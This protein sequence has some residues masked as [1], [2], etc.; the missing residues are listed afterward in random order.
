[1]LVRILISCW[2]CK[3]S[4]LPWASLCASALLYAESAPSVGTCRSLMCVLLVSRS[5][6]SED[7]KHLLASL[8]PAAATVDMSQRQALPR[9]D[10][11]SA[12]LAED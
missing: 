9:D 5:D 6:V 8:D 11:K 10:Q 1:M 4:C 3:F 7:L 12:Q 2:R